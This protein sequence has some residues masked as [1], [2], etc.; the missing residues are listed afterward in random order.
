MFEE[1]DEVTRSA[2][3]GTSVAEDADTEAD[4]HAAVASREYPA[5]SGK[6]ATRVGGPQQDVGQLDRL[7]EVGAYREPPQ[8]PSRVQES[9]NV[10]DVA[11]G[12]VGT[13]DDVGLQSQPRRQREPRGSG[14]FAEWFV[15]PTDEELGSGRD[16]SGLQGRVEACTRHDDRVA[17][18]GPTGRGGKADPI[19]GRPDN[20]HVAQPERNGDVE[21]EFVEKLHTSGA[22]EVSTRLIAWEGGLVDER[23]S[24]SA[25]REHKRSD[26]ARGTRSHDEDVEALVG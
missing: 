12:A 10:C 14:A 24:C 17:G 20:D 9:R 3:A 25:S 23:N 4:V 1:S 8:Q 19:A 5:V 22:D 6:R 11:R 16:R 2:S 13:D 26:A 7:L 15:G 18:V 21:V